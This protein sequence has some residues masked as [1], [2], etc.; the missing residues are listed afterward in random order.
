MKIVKRWNMYYVRHQIDPATLHRSHVFSTILQKLGYPAIGQAISNADL[1]F[2]GVT[3]RNPNLKP[4]KGS[5]YDAVR[6]AEGE[7]AYTQIVVTQRY[8]L[9]CGRFEVERHTLELREPG[10]VITVGKLDVCSHCHPDHW[11]F[12]SHMPSQVKWRKQRERNMQ[13]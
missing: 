4:G 1:G 10:N 3:P 5:E 2:L 12:T 9:R 6:Y 13:L 8:C 11:L 7:Y